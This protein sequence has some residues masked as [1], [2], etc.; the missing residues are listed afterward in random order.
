MEYMGT[1]MKFS[2]YKNTDIGVIAARSSE[3]VFSE[4]A[5]DEESEEDEDGGK[6]SEVVLY[7]KTTL[8]SKGIHQ[9]ARESIRAH[10]GLT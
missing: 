8:R 10:Q 1:Q 9:K 4:P 6:I 2:L 5:N 7:P 3:D